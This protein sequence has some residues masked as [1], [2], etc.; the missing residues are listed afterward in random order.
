MGIE[1]SCFCR[2]FY[3]GG[4]SSLSRY[5]YTVPSSLSASRSNIYSF[6]QLSQQLGTIGLTHYTGNNSVFLNL[7]RVVYSI[8]KFCR[9]VH[10]QQ[11]KFH[12]VYDAQ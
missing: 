6:R 9:L 8:S 5:A 3:F 10:N 7:S 4:S 11:S 1:L 12:H 2:F